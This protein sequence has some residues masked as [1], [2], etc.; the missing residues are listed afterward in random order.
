[1]GIYECGITLEK[2]M[3]MTLDEILQEIH[4]M[5]QNLLV[6]ERKYGVPSELF[7]EAYQNGEEPADSAW[8]L[9]WAEWAAT[10]KILQ[11]RLCRRFIGATIKE[12]A[13]WQELSVVI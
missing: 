2:V 12:S 10:Y 4:A 11:R 3:M 13:T 9:D 6:F 7:F 8:V 5:R 1:M